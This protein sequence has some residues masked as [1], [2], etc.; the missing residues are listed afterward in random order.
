[1]NKRNFFLDQTNLNLAVSKVID[2]IYGV[3]AIDILNRSGEHS[4]DKN[5]KMGA[6]KAA[7]IVL[8][9]MGE[10]TDINDEDYKFAID[11]LAKS[12]NLA[13]AIFGKGTT[14]DNSAVAGELLARIIHGGHWV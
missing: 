10:W 12:K 7:K 11:N 3:T 9:S 13:D 2:N 5:L 6:E 4:S 14:S 1:M 8:I